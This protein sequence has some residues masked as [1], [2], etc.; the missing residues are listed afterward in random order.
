MY[1]LN[2]IRWGASHD[3]TLRPGVGAK[4]KKVA[5]RDKA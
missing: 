1:G 4:L 5:V 2:S 3:V